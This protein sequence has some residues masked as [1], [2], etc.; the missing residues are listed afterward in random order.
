M[1][2]QLGHEEGLQGQRRGR[3]DLLGTIT[4]EDLDGR[5][6]C[7]LPPIPASASQPM[8]AWDMGFE[9]EKTLC[10]TTQ[11]TQCT[12]HA[13]WM[14]AKCMTTAESSK[15]RYSA[16]KCEKASSC[17]D[18]LVIGSSKKDPLCCTCS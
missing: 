8:W 15:G 17:E 7:C 16:P 6:N 2:M 4:W 9:P 18:G 10:Q 11:L 5:G 3:A 14:G 12:M 1:D 13:F